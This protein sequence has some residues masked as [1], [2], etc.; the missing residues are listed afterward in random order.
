MT[1]RRNSNIYDVIAER[2]AGQG[3]DVLQAMCKRQQVHQAR[4]TLKGILNHKTEGHNEDQD[5]HQDP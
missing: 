1:I 4:P 2:Q 3:S 5:N